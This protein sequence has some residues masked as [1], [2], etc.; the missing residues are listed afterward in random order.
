[1][2]IAI[3]IPCHHRRDLLVRA[4]A[5]V[6]DWPVFVVDDSPDGRI[7]GDLGANVTRVRT[8]GEI[9]FARAVNAGLAAAEAAGFSHALALNDDAVPAPGCVA[10]L[11]AA[12]GPGVGAVGP[13]IYGAEGIES[14]GFSVARWGRVR[15]R[16][17]LER[18]ESEAPVAVD[19][20]SGAALMIETG[21][22][23]DVRYRHGFEDLDL[24]Q[25]LI[26]DSLRVLLVPGARCLHL[27]GATV[28]RTSRA[29][30]RHA[31][32]GHLRLVG[33]GWRAPVVIGLAFAQVIREGGPWDRLG[34]VAEG[35]RDY[36]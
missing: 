2:R 26:V 10:A 36:K 35:W 19:A 13:V 20:L 24:C 15:A 16:R 6:R 23:F 30:Q 18:P 32:S 28:A 22:R 9:G 31:V 21:R 1:M 29:A 33:G 12:W 7:D 4:L 27:G 34:G 25:R 3:V 14:A 8:A 11:A 5:A 17:S